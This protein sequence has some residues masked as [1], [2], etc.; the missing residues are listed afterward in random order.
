[1]GSIVLI[2]DLLKNIDTDVVE[3][4]LWIDSNKNCYCIEMF[5]QLLK[6]N[7]RN[8]DEIYTG[9]KQGYYTIVPKDSTFKILREDKLNENR[10]HRLEKVYSIVKM[11]DNDENTPYCFL[12]NYRGKYI[13]EAIKKYEGVAEKTIYNYIRRYW[14]GGR[15][16]EALMDNYDNCGIS[17]EKNYTRK[18]GRPSFASKGIEN[19]KGF[20]ITD[21]V[22]K[23]FEDGVIK[24]YR[25]GDKRTIA[26]TLRNIKADYYYDKKWYE[27]PSYD[28][29]YHWF[30]ENQNIDETTKD[31]EGEKSYQNNYRALHSDSIYETNGPGFR[32]QVDATV[33]PVFLVNRI[34]RSLIVGRPILYFAVDTFS[35]KVVGMHIGLNYPSWDGMAN[36]L[37]NSFEDKVK[38]CHL[39]GIDITESMWNAK[40]APKVILGDRGELISKH[41]DTIVK[42]LYIG[43]ENAPSYLGSAKGAVEKKFDVIESFIKKDLPGRIMKK[44]RERGEKDYRKD[45]K[46]DIVQFTQIVI[47]E[48]LAQNKS[49]KFEYPL[50]KEMILDG[51]RPISDEIWN[52]GLKEKTG[53]LTNIEEDKL[54]YFLLRKHS[55]SINGKGIRVRRMYYTC[56]LAERENWFSRAKKSKR[57][58]VAYD[59]RCMNNVLLFDEDT[60]KYIE[61]YIN[62]ELTSNDKYI[63]KSY[64]EIVQYDNEVL[65][66]EDSEWC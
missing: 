43:V 24:Y 40:G 39:Y 23:Q 8:L 45:A 32:Y 4:I 18:P 38:Y 41:S 30:N 58:E 33:F 20:I 36:L 35:R 62:R 29:F 66:K 54:R 53:F 44:Y 2:N 48:V 21:E 56:D 49:V 17:K 55:A 10:K 60:K 27:K 22:K 1:M 11:I 16:K 52:W 57:C 64:E 9:F 25:N 59:G 51:I 34:D 65:G 63:D 47:N 31:R 3:R 7:I 13:K 6:I 61:C 12:K 14:Q 42:N 28:Q 15:N 46:M 5:T 50:L 26:E 37:Y 19:F